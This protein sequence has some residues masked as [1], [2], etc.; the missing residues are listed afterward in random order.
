[1]SLNQTDASIIATDSA[2]GQHF[3]ECV[4]AMQ[5]D[6]TNVKLQYDYA[7]TERHREINSLVFTID[8]TS[9]YVVAIVDSNDRV[10]VSA[11]EEALTMRG[12]LKDADERRPLISLAP[13]DFVQTICGFVPGTVPP[14]G[15][16]PGP[17]VTVVDDSLAGL[18]VG[19]GG[20][21]Q[22]SCVI[23]FDTLLRLPGVIARRIRDDSSVSSDKQGR[24]RILSSVSDTHAKPF[25]C[26]APPDTA[27]AT[28]FLSGGTSAN[29]LVPVEVT[30]VGRI[31]AVRRMARKLIF[32]TFAPTSGPLDP[33]Q[34]L[35][36][37]GTS[38]EELSVQL[39]IGKTF[40]Q[41]MDEDSAVDAMRR[42]KPGQLVL[43]QGKTN[44]GN[45]DSLR[46]WCEKRSLDLVV[47]DFSVLEEASH[48][49]GE[50]LLRS[51]PVVPPRHST[52]V[53]GLPRSPDPNTSYLRLRHLY[54]EPSSH[55]VVVDSMETVEAFARDLSAHLLEL[56]SGQ[57]KSSSPE[58]AFA[59]SLVGIDCE[60]KPN[61]YMLAPDEPQPVLLLQVCLH[62]TRKVYLFDLQTL[63]RPLLKPESTLNDLEM[64][65]SVAMYDLLSSQRLVKVGFQLSQDLRRLAA[66][67]PHVPAFRQAESVLDAGFLA[68]KVMHL[69]R[70]RHSKLVTS[71]LG[72][73]TERYLGKP[74]DKTEQVSDWSFRPLSIEQIEYAALDAVVTPAIVEKLIS[75][76]DA[77]F[78]DKPELGRFKHDTAFARQL[79]SWRY[80]FLDPRDDDAIA[81]LNAKRVIADIPVV[82]QSWVTGE[83]TPKLPEVPA[84]GDG[85]FTDT[86]GT[87]RV[88]SQLVSIDQS[89]KET[90]IET[91]IG[92]RVGKSKDRC[93]A[94]LLVGT[95]ALPEGAKLDFPHRS[96]FVEF[97]NA[98][99]LFVNMPSTP[100]G[101]APRNFP[102]EWLE[103]GQV[104]TWFLRQND[105]QEGK[106]DIAKKMT[107]AD[108]TQMPDVY[109]FVRLGKGMFL[110]CGRCRVVAPSMAQDGAPDTWSLV[111]LH[112]ILVDWSKLQNCYDFLQL[113]NPSRAAALGLA[114][115]DVDTSSSESSF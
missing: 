83:H 53:M 82:T 30:T 61:L 3:L 50:S 51:V 60:W 86:S 42:L 74:L 34:L 7:I 106:S 57:P 101:R 56:T 22:Q 23:D 59:T 67:Y 70:Q 80:L 109:L 21:E 27:L 44:V 81:K 95:A 6:G 107:D 36:K 8:G 96:G 37:S 103:D 102:N 33:T 73:L 24:S 12:Y 94:N 84:D 43:I 1:M 110:F 98:V 55:V 91:L 18:L 114:E 25:F 28:Q 79:L 93:L 29:P 58:E 54:G 20:F 104:L 48:K 75:S 4:M 87:L 38:N 89:L 63:L 77:T 64:T 41:S 39:I 52:S 72:R 78:Y 13:S 85:Q 26:V 5:Q 31:A 62:Q 69:S 10:N 111:K 99:A 97:E 68:K 108:T 65:L 15:H 90:M 9:E 14:F 71:S 35:W 11:L 115:R 19:G 49:A 76:I 17:S 2:A 45:R 32:A 100:N 113:V 40:C 47:F 92:E 16:L 105:W 66:S 46:N 112:L 88:P